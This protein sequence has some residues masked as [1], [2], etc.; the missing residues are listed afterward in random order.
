ML[1]K[2]NVMD[3]V[4]DGWTAGRTEPVSIINSKKYICV[5]KI[6]IYQTVKLLSIL[7]LFRIIVESYWKKKLPKRHQ[8]FHVKQGSLR[9]KF[10]RT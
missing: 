1:Q 9:N 8:L 4:T 2:Q 7:C 3:R 6:L 5:E 10:K